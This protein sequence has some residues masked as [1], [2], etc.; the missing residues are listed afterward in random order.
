MVIEMPVEMPEV[1]AAT[2][3]VD[4]DSLYQTRWHYLV[5]LAVLLVDD[6]AT[7]EDV[8]QEAF[9]ALHRKADTLRDPA[10]ALSYVQTAVVN[11]SRSVLRRR[12]VARKHLKVAEPDDTPGA[13]DHVLLR[14]EHR[15]AL[16]AVRR[17]PRRQREVIVLR[18][19]AGLSERDIAHALGI[20]PGSVKANASR[21]MAALQTILGKEAADEWT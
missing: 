17:L 11:R 18:Y 9:I 5:R 2:P 1:D 7:A 19:W 4:I 21:A 6:L 16:D 8:V 20:A 13:D 15:A 14:E 3:R 10:A 12:T